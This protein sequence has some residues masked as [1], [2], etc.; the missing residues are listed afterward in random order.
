MSR[1]GA[2]AQPPDQQP[3]VLPKRRPRVIPVL[4]LK[5]GLLHKPMKFKSPKYVGDPR[6]A[7][8][9]FNDKGAD[10]LALIDMG[11]TVQRREPDYA[12]IEEIVTESFMPVAYGGGVHTYDHA[13]RILELGVEKIV[14]N[15]ALTTNPI[16]SEKVAEVFGAQSVIGC[17][18]CRKSL[19]GGYSV[20]V[21]AGQKRC[22][23][24][25]EDIARKIVS[26][27]VGEIIVQSIDREGSGNG[28][29]L[30]LVRRVSSAVEV[31]V[32]ALGGAGNPRHFKEAVDAG[33]AAAAAGSMFVFTGPRRAVLIT[34]PQDAQLH[35][36]FGTR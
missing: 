12:L 31:P 26:R 34:Y 20:Y 22:S 7:V 33:A 32:I 19:F 18:D 24:N 21:E 15:T 30:A 14:L 16:L 9:I 13:A 5:D 36:A 10:E 27:G 2:E 23:G 3:L 17:I 11:A 35:A 4:L 8:K 29:D 6:V 25:P 1:P 28:Y